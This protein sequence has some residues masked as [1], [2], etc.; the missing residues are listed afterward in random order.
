MKENKEQ[1]ILPATDRYFSKYFSDFSGCAG[2]NGGV[3]FNETGVY[4]ALPAYA[5]NI[6]GSTHD[7]PRE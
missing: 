2:A 7:I 4:D 6:R 1:Y 5:I 3:E